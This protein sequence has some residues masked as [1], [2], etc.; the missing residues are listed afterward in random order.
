MLGGEGGVSP[1]LL[2]ILPTNQRGDSAGLPWGSVPTQWLGHG[3]AP[4]HN[5]V[6]GMWAF[7]PSF[8][9]FLAASVAYW[10]FSGSNQSHSC[11]PIPH[12]SWQ[13]WIL[14]FFFL[15]Q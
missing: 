11:W 14:L 12:T 10:K 7:L 15:T 4:G 9:P 2:V 13:R 8:L 5:L 6:S 3:L 1:T